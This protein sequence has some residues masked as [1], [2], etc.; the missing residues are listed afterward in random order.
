M[1]D[2]QEK[3][4]INR[5]S[6]KPDI[7][8]FDQFRNWQF[9]HGVLR[10]N[11]LTNIG[12]SNESSSDDSMDVSDESS[13]DEL[14]RIKLFKSVKI[15]GS[16]FSTN[17]FDGIEI[18]Q[19]IDNKSFYPLVILVYDLYRKDEDLKTPQIY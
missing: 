14:E 10:G 16:L 11:E 2:I 12:D 1:L 4:T 17:I 6:F 5:G 3:S 7:T 18:G 19:Q 15:N 8:A 9:T 13:G